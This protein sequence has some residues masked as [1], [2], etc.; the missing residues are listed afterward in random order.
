M[1]HCIFAGVGCI[2]YVCNAITFEIFNLESLFLVSKSIY[3]SHTQ[4]TKAKTYTVYSKC[5]AKQLEQSRM[6]H[7]KL[8]IITK[9]LKKHKNVTQIRNIHNLFLHLVFF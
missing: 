3:L 5:S 2:M 7:M 4:N 1:A 6:Q 9:T 8:R